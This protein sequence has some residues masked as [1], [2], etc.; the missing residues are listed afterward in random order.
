MIVSLAVRLRISAKQIAAILA[1]ILVPAMFANLFQFWIFWHC[2]SP[3]L[4]DDWLPSSSTFRQSFDSIF[5]RHGSTFTTFWGEFGCHWTGIPLVII[6]T[7]LND[8]LRICIEWMS[9]AILLLTLASLLKILNSLARLVRKNRWRTAWYIVCSNPVLSTYFL[10]IIFF[11]IADVVYR[12]STVEEGT[13]WFPL[14]LAIILSAAG[15]APRVFNSTPLRR[16]F[17]FL[18][19]ISWLTYSIIGN[20]Y[21]I[22]C[23]HKRFY[24]ADKKP[25]INYDNLK[26]LSVGAAGRIEYCD[27]LDSVQTFD[28][29]LNTLIIPKG[30]YMR[31][32]GW[33]LDILAGAPASA[34]WLY[35]DNSKPYPTTYG[36][37]N[38]N[39]RGL[40]SGA[41]YKYSGFEGL[42][43]T[44]DLDA[45]WHFLTMKIVSTNGQVLYNTDAKIRFLVKKTPV[46]PRINVRQLK[47]L[48]EETEASIQHC[49]FV[50]ARFPPPHPNTL[51]IPARAYIHTLGWA[52]DQQ[53]KAPALTVLIYI[54]N[55]RKYQPGY[56]LDNDQAVEKLHSE[57]YRPS[58]FEALIPT[59]G[60]S[61]G[62]HSLSIK[63][64]SS[65]GL[66]LYNTKA[67]LRFILVE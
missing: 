2:H 40:W 52:V 13:G 46:K 64:V 57:K 60:L 55:S 27:Y 8:A 12:S 19:T 48:D 58:G 56:G 50:D 63:V 25:N 10:F 29:H 54:D 34:V 4:I 44:K 3:Y 33:A 53:H 42:I 28:P 36:F 23:I 62:W 47:L 39:D 22:G 66:H 61:P 49:D 30:D 1:V 31:T 18:I 16:V 45:G 17:F 7:S 43:P 65:D 5:L 14:I 9:K 26:Q 51:I 21:A 11:F 38:Y 35:I 20:Y 37:S 15:L 6:S 24:D 67:H 41:K 59:E 32:K